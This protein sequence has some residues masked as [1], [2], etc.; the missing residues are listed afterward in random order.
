MAAKIVKTLKD[1][2]VNTGF[3]SLIFKNFLK[4]LFGKYSYICKKCMDEDTVDRRI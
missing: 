2:S 4:C 3:F 1:C